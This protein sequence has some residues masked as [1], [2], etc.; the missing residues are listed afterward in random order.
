[1]RKF[2]LLPVSERIIHLLNSLDMAAKEPPEMKKRWRT[3][4]YGVAAQYGKVHG[5]RKSDFDLIKDRPI[6]ELYKI[7]VDYHK[8]L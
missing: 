5:I 1:M 8:T 6:D 3:D 4:I 7:I 2:S